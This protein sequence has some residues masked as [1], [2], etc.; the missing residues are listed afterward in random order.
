VA[1]KRA[2]RKK[3]KKEK[4]KKKE[5]WKG[6]GTSVN[7]GD[8]SLHWGWDTQRRMRKEKGG[9]AEKLR[10]GGRTRDIHG[11]NCQYVWSL[12]RLKQMDGKARAEKKGGKGLSAK[13]V[14]TKR[15][16]QEGRKTHEKN[17][18]PRE[19]KQCQAR[20]MIEGGGK[21]GRGQGED[22]GAV[23]NLVTAATVISFVKERENRRK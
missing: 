17:G 11:T 14:E 8:V 3:K 1:K 13:K 22:F 12:D 20:K 9:E 23:R 19:K 15:Q 18:H 7:R 6:A 4:Q 10:V 5:Q 16:M 21:T 2:C